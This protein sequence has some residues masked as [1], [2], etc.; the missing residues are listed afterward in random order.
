MGGW[1][2]PP[3]AFS[4]ADAHR[5]WIDRL[6]VWGRIRNVRVDVIYNV[7]EERSQPYALLHPLSVAIYILALPPADLGL[8]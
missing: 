7:V 8:F 2:L 4:I 3:D 1:E 5:A 6:H